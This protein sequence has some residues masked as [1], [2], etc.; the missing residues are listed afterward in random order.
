MDF[1]SKLHT[2]EFLLS[3]LDILKDLSEN[4][5]DFCLTPVAQDL[6]ILKAKIGDESIAHYFA[7]NQPMWIHTKL[8]HEPEILLIR[9]DLDTTVAHVLAENQKSWI[10][11]APL[12]NL[13][14]MLTEDLFGIT[15]IEDLIEYQQ[16]DINHQAFFNKE[17]LSKKTASTSATKITKTIAETLVSKNKISMD[18]M[19]IRLI[20]NGAAFINLEPMTV[21]VGNS[22]FNEIEPL[23]NESLNPLIAL[24]Q[25]IALFSTCA[26]NI[27]RISI[28]NGMSTLQEW[29]ELQDKSEKILKSAVHKL[30]ALENVNIS[31]DFYCKPGYELALKLMAEIN[32][33][34]IN[35]DGLW[36][37][38][39]LEQKQIEVGY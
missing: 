19:A 8:I 2:K 24:K 4:C 11:I 31:P 35:V 5:V 17:I 30:G 25:A 18:A 9:D 21:H 6:D 13:Q 20:S 23:I 37:N 12:Y 7:K 10:T 34:S 14:I 27:E 36:E 29:K 32:I 39:E 26:N 16:I 1:D 22:I 15:V 3:N 28:D 33:K 38:V